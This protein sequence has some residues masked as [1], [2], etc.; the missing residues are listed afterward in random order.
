MLIRIVEKKVGK[1]GRRPMGCYKIT[2]GRGTGSTRV[3]SVMECRQ[4]PA[5]HGACA[6]KSQWKES[7][8]S[9][10]GLRNC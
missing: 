5:R 6:G 9:E 1:E 8:V 4:C 2:G 3:S 10:V 7:P